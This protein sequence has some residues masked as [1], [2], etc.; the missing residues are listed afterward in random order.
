MNELIADA[1]PEKDLFLDMFIRDLTLEDS[2]LDLVDNSID[3]IISERSIDVSEALEPVTT[4]LVSP[5]SA[6]A[7]VKPAA[8]NITLN[9]EH[10][11]IVD[12]CGGISVDDARREVFRFG[13]PRDAKVGQLGVYGI[14]LK[15]AIF[16]IGNSI[17]IESRTATEGFRMAINVSEWS[18][19]RKW[20]LPFEVIDGTGNPLTAGTSITIEAFRPEVVERVRSGRLEGHLTEMIGRTYCLFLDRYVKLTLNGH[21]VE[22]DYIPLGS[23]KETTVAKELFQDNGVTVTIYA[24]LAARD[25]EGRWQAADAGWYVAC[26]GR[27]VVGIPLSRVP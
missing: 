20:E 19:N 25:K 23:S 14:G 24:G 22:P 5:H 10:F 26:N 2:I 13:H 15:R 12:N 6:R 18:K 4:N 7:T 17:T 3:S 9:D 21:K 16:K 11:R 1:S 8:I 27:L